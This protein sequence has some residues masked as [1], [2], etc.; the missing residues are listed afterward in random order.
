M[1]LKALETKKTK[2]KERNGTD[3][4]PYNKTKT[5]GQTHNHRV[6]KAE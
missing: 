5:C 2:R 6:K 3:D 4:V 1:E